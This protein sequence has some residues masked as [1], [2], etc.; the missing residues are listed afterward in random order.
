MLDGVRELVMERVLVVETLLLS[1][2]ERE[3][4]FE[5]EILIV[6]VRD[7]LTLEE[8]ELLSEIVALNV[9]V[10]E[11]VGEIDVV[12]VIVIVADTDATGVEVP[13]LLGDRV[14]VPVRVAELVG[15]G[16]RVSEMLA[17]EVYVIVGETDALNDNDD[18]LEGVV[19]GEGVGV[20]GW[21]S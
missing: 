5:F 11:I 1:D 18:V 10:I 15:V 2:A 13:V 8:P 16:V 12:V 7:S 6:P 21:V 3:L 17:V 14:G 19:E 4:V 9:A 20:L